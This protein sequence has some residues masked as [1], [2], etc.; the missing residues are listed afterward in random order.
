VFFY[1]LEIVMGNPIDVMIASEWATLQSS[2]EGWERLVAGESD[3]SVRVG[4]RRGVIR[5]AQDDVY[6]IVIETGEEALEV[7]MRDGRSGGRAYAARE[8]F[9]RAI[10]ELIHAGRI[11]AAGACLPPAEN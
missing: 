1:R 7:C 6:Q 5:T 4:A 8:G 10:Y 11:I 9:Q 2:I 3:L